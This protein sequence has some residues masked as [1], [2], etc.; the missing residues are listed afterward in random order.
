MMLAEEAGTL[1][2]VDEE[3]DATCARVASTETAEEEVPLIG[4]SVCCGRCEE[5][6]EPTEMEWERSAGGRRLVVEEAALGLLP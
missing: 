2:V 5:T 6:V 1:A 4:I 3:A